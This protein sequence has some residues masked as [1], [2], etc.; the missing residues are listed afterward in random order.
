MNEDITF[1]VNSCDKYEDAWHPFFECLHIFFPEMH[2][3]IVLNTETKSYASKHFSIQTINVPHKMT[4]S[5]RMQNVLQQIHTKYVFFLLD[6]YFLMSPFDDIR[7]QK[8]LQYM[9]DHPEVGIVDISPP[10]AAN[11][12]EAKQNAIRMKDKPDSFA[13]REKKEWNIVCTPAIWRRDA[14]LRILKPHEDIWQFEYY[15]GIRANLLHIPV[16]RYGTHTPTIYEYEYQLW[17]GKGITSGHWLSGNKPF[18]EQLGIEVNYDRLGI[19]DANN[20]EDVKKYNRRNPL[21]LIKKIPRKIRLICD[22]KKSLK[23]EE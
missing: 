20:V 14:F 6:D 2:Y 1:L 12:A 11:A 3:P 15:S 18:F 13:I 9:E 17:G 23:V 22:R 8:V 19:I 10:W 16:V 5:K 21:R 4:W 7:F